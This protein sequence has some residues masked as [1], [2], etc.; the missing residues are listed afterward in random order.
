MSL[1]SLIAGPAD[2]K[3]L[4]IA[5]LHIL[6]QEIRTFLIDK[7]SCLGGH[8]GSNLGIVELTIATHRVFAS[9]HDLLLFDTGPQAYVHKI[10]TGRCAKFDSLRQ[11]DGLSGYPSCAESVHDLIENSHASTALCYADGLAKAFALRGAADWRVV[12]IVGDGA[13]TGGMCWE[14]L[15]NLGVAPE[16]PVIIVLNDNGRSYSPTVGGLARHLTELRQ[17]EVSGLTLFEDLG[18]AYLGPVDGHDIAE[19]ENALRRADELHRPVVVHYVTRKGRGYPPAEQDDTDHLHTVG[20]IDPGTGRARYVGRPTWTSVFAEEIAAIGTEREDAVCV[21]AAM[22]HPTGLGDRPAL[23]RARG[24]GPSQA[25]GRAPIGAHRRGHHH[26][27]SARRTDSPGAGRRRGRHLRG[28][29]RPAAPV[30]ATCH[31]GSDPARPRPGRHR[32]HHRR[33]QAT[34]QH[35]P[36]EG[37]SQEPGMTLYLLSHWQGESDGIC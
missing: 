18:L 28:H 14:A 19:L 31:S 8:L 13:L 35:T 2:L 34:R 5:T 16:R 7:V 25:G 33:P 4:P 10:L 9:P 36:G 17:G 20:V 37:H 1:L 29:L 23:D 27:W 24:P 12:A 22:L 3:R 15:N 26:Q 32:H 21:T 6:A 11:A 30:P